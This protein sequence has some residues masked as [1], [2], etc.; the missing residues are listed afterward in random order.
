MNEYGNNVTY[1]WTSTENRVE[2]KGTNGKS[3]SGSYSSYKTNGFDWF[4][5]LT[6]TWEKSNQ[7][8]AN[9]IKIATLKSTYYYYYPYSLTTSSSTAGEKKGIGTDDTNLYEMLFKDTNNDQFYWLG[10]SFVNAYADYAWFGVRVVNNGN[11]NNYDLYNSN[12]DYNYNNYG[13]RPAA[14][15]KLWY[16]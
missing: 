3:G 16:S 10:S 4:N 7:D 13:V 2:S 1:S 6:K 8:T 9:P 15:K 12:G 5:E 11:V 14:S